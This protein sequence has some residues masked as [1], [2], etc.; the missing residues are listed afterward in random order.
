MTSRLPA[1]ANPSE[2]ERH[3]LIAE[4][5]DDP[6]DRSHEHRL[7][8]SP[9]HGLGPRD[10]RDERIEDAGH[11][12]GRRQAGF[13]AGAHHVLAF[14]ALDLD[15]FERRNVDSVAF[16]EPDRRFGRVAVGVECRPR[17]RPDHALGTIR[18]PIADS[19]D[20]D[21]DAPRRAEHRDPLGPQAR[22]GQRRADRVAQVSKRLGEE[23]GRN[24]LGPDLE[25]Q[26]SRHGSPPAQRPARPR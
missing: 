15:S 21:G 8:V 17:G 5:R 3:H 7:A 11:H 14:F 22:L 26:V 6:V 23:R 2:L 25:K 13:F 1:G 9:S 16:G 19:G 10:T 20:D 18:L 4:H 24:L 12:V